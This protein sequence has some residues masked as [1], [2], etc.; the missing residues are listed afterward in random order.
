M[1]CEP[2][3]DCRLV[4]WSTVEMDSR[5][6]RSSAGQ[7]ESAPSVLS[8]PVL[9][10]LYEKPY[11]LMR[12]AVQ[13][14]PFV[15]A[16][17]HSGRL[18]PRAFLSQS[19]LS[20]AS[21]RRSEDAF[22]DGLFAGAVRLGA[23]LIAARFPRA[24]VDAN[25]AP[26][27]LDSSMFNGALSVPV[28]ASSPRVSA[29]LGVIPRIVRDGA[30]VYLTRLSP[31]E[32]EERLLRLHRPYQ[33]ALLQIAEE[34]RAH[35]GAAVIVDCH[36]MPSAAAA[37]DVVLGDRYGTSAS[38]ALIRLAEDAFRACGFSVA[39]N[40]PYAGGYTTH[41][42]GQPHKGMHALQIEINRALYLKEEQIAPNSDFDQVSARLCLALAELMTIDINLLRSQMGSRL[43]A[44]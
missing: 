20:G 31:H 14:A 39:R 3:V 21:L 33:D 2:P 5:S 9:W 24:Y 27:E 41:R 10:D 44:E 28:D 42:H 17:P 40:V 1:H 16:S 13:R 18:Y 26:T 15:F 11:S 37:I 43:A 32:A 25:R 29:G 4:W 7:A 35:F 19:R 30:E 36:S 22:A 6:N 12:P 23:P 34:T 38:H 8:D